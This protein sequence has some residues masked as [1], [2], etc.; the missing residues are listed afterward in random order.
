MHTLKYNE[1]IRRALHEK[2]HED[3]NVMVMGLGVPDPTGIFGTTTDL[4]KEFGEDRV[5]DVPCAE[6]GMTG[7][8]IGLAL[9]GKKVVFSHQ[10]VDFALLALEQIINQA[11][12]WHFMFGGQ[13]TVPLVVRMIVG[14]GWGQG[15]QHSQFL[16]AL[17]AH[18]P[19]LKVYAPV[20]PSDARLL[21]RHAIEDP[22]P[23]VFFEHRWLHF[24]QERVDL[25]VTTT[26]ERAHVLREGRDVTLVSC[27][28][29]V[30]EC[31]E[32]AAHLAQFG[33]EAEVI[34]LRVLRPLDIATVGESVQRTKRLVILEHTWGQGSIG[35]EILAQL[36]TAGTPFASAPA[37][38]TL[39]DHPLPTA[40]SLAADYYPGA[41]G[42][43]AAVRAQF[44]R[45]EIPLPLLPDGFEEDKPNPAFKGPF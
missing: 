35:A 30:L 41:A 44:S 14:R 10:R 38:L 32:A 45:P 37:R 16:P 29:G 13:E 20:F 25:S 24:G 39:P 15:P 21:L 19:G 6:N 5:M 9:G 40:R 22:N 11:A 31:R 8:A 27:S 4:A 7:I 23:V 2:L 43:V 26:S 1:A 17:F 3:P 42:I 18:I 12:K 28:Y 33:I 36:A 34:D